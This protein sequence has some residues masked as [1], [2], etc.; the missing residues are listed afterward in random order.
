MKIGSASEIQH[1]YTKQTTIYYQSYGSV[2]HDS[3]YNNNIRM[4]VSSLRQICYYCQTA[5]TERSGR[6]GENINVQCN[7]IAVI[8]IIQVSVV[9]EIHSHHAVTATLNSIMSGVVVHAEMTKEQVKLR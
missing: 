1:C 6:D 7:T 4:P 5:E 8:I 2:I 3:Y 9:A